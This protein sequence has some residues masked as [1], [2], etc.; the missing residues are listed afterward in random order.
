MR[1]TIIDRRKN[2]NGK[3]IPNRRRFLKRYS[4]N[5]KKTIKDQIRDGKINDI[6]NGSDATVNI[7]VKD[8]KE[9]RI[10]HGTGGINRHV[11]PHN[12]EF[13]EGDRIP[14]PPSGEG[15]GNGASG[16][17]EGE[18]GFSFTLTK[19]EFLNY[20]FEDLELPDL[21]EKDITIVDEVRLK[22]A[23]FSTSGNPS[24]LD[25]LRSMKEAI[26]RRAAL[27]GEERAE[28]NKINDEITALNEQ[29]F[30]I[31]RD[32]K[33]A[34]VTA[35]E[36]KRNELEAKLLELKSGI[37]IPFVDDMDLRYRQ[38][39][40]EPVPACQAV[41]FCIMDVS[42]SMGEWHK[43]L[44][45]R[46]FM[47]LYLFLH[48]NYER[49]ELVF[50]RHHSDARECDEEEFFYGRDSGGTVVSTALELMLEIAKERYNS[51]HW[52]I[53]VAH[54]SD[55]DAWGDDILTTQE[56]F[57]EIVSKVQYYFYIEVSHS[58]R[59]GWDSEL[60]TALESMNAEN[61]AVAHVSDPS[62]IFPVFRGLF[63]K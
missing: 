31:L 3:S 44:A 8:V 40:E 34:D 14:R 17:G 37:K 1:H 38:W 42:G 16:D 13:I 19:E 47:L 24:R 15:Q 41:M 62:D 11:L 25:I 29:I 10:H 55:G 4:K 57:R 26:G 63:E 45:K 22:R 48:R 21:V 61:F 51:V 56:Y 39:T 2:G 36:T 58:S 32:D 9:P 28:V 53:Y 50:I 20:F 30:N 12:K 27:S 60:K 43:D 33:K 6:V 7:P 54:A 18:D 49:I 46:F 59:T 5:V 23:G 52:N 35:F